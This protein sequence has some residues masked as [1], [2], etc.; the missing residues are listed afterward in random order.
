MED[1]TATVPEKTSEFSGPANG[2]ASNKVMDFTNKFMAGVFKFGK[3]I[4]ALFSLLSILVMIGALIY[5]VF[6][7]PSSV[8]VPDFE[9]PNATE[10]GA[11]DED[12]KV[13]NKLFKELRDKYGKKVDELIE[14]CGLDAKDDYNRI[15]EVL[16]KFDT[17]DLR[18][19][20]IKGAIAYVKDFKAYADSQ[21]E[22]LEPRDYLRSIDAFTDSFE[23]AIEAAEASKVVSSMKRST[24]LTVCG[25][26]LVGLILFLIIPLLIK[27]EENTRK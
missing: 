26:A 7:G 16:A 18:S 25:S 11:K 5:Y 6:A 1:N 17:D 21:K 4:A 24:A 15:I 19:L 12:G 3:V 2:C 10:S 14:I 9:K 22:K 20:H 23:K 27:I 13:S 8:K